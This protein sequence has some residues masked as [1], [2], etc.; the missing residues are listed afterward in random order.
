[1]VEVRMT[2][3]DL[4]KALRGVISWSDFCQ[5]YSSEKKSYLLRNDGALTS[6]DLKMQFDLEWAIVEK[7]NLDAICSAALDGRIDE[8]DI[9]FI[10]NALLLSAFDFE[11]D[12]LE[13]VCHFLSNIEKLDEVREAKSFL[14]GI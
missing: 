8:S 5:K 13:D 4:E 2:T 1:M 11:D 7:K 9:S 14:Q 10:T 3:S 12:V 6:V